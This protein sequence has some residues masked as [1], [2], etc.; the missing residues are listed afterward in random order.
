[1]SR[2]RSRDES[3]PPTPRRQRS[4]RRVAT[5]YDAVAG[6]VGYE[7]FL[8]ASAVDKNPNTSNQPVPPEEVL[9]RRK[10]APLRYEET[11]TYFASSR[12]DPT[13]QVLPASDLLKAI[14]AYASGYYATGPLKGKWDWRSMDETALLAMG[15]LLEETMKDRIEATGDL[16]FVEGEGDVNGLK[17]K[18]FW[19]GRTWRRSVIRKAATGPK[20]KGKGFGSRET[21]E[22]G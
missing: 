19:D 13:T 1:M 21:D 5:V 3:Q 16:A 22:D 18:G 12:L 6:R 7:A 4:P 17:G 11:D 15:I 8:P 9:F 2:K 10:G 14:H 20:G